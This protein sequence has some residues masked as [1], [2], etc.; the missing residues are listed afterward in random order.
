MTCDALH[1]PLRCRSLYQAAAGFVY[2]QGKSLFE[3][4]AK[5]AGF[6][7]GKVKWIVA[8]SDALPGL[9]AGNRVTDVYAPGFVPI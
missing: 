7:A 4:F 6:D 3:G 9:L 1:A 8:G 5:A 2:S